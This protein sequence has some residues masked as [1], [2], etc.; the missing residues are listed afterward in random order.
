[1][2]YQ[3]VPYTIFLIASAL[4]TS[5]LVVYGIRHR[6]A[7]GTN[8]LALCMLIGTLWSVANALE[9]SALT[10]EQKLFWANLQYI[11]YSLGPAAWFFTTCQFTG[12]VHWIQWK[13]VLPL[14]IVPA[15]TIFLVWFDPVWGLVRT[16]FSLTTAG[17]IY[18]LQKQY[19]PWFYVHFA[20]AYALNFASIFLAGRAAL[21]RNSIY[22]GQALFLLGGVSL[23]VTSNLLYLA[24]V[25]L[26]TKHDLTPLVFSVAAGLMFWGIYRVDLF[27]LVPIARER[28]LEAMETGVI[29]VN[30]GGRVV[31]LNPASRRMFSI[32]EGVGALLRDIAPELASLN[33]EEGV[34]QHLEIHRRVQGEERY[35]KVSASA[36]TDQRGHV[37]GTVMA[38]TDITTLKQVQARL[39]LEQ[40][41]AAIAQERA[42]ITQD[43]HDNLGQTLAYSSLQVRAVRR[44]LERGN[45]EKGRQ[46][47][48][49]LGEV[50][51]DVQREMRDYVRGMRTKEYENTSLDALLEKQMNRLKEH[52]GLGSQAVVLELTEHDFGLHEK[53]Q[54]CQIVKEAINNVLKHSSA[55]RVTVRLR[56]HVENWV[57]S[58]I[59]NGVG[60]DPSQVLETKQSGF[61]LS[62]LAER[63]RVL[64]GTMEIR[65]DPGGTEIKVEFPRN[66]GGFNHAHH[67]C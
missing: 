43:L 64:G 6:H 46:Y 38:I 2:H 18:V 57:L 66:D 20:Q 44:E 34:D 53:G 40:Q 30:E 3:F 54:I 60:F 14:L 22:Q 42:R 32:Q 58:I 52:G 41:E 21:N 29:V 62:I 49:R 5:A 25:R 51:H 4:M 9:I 35:F 39:I 26:A 15:L 8:I 56:P 11:A 67:D 36:I 28:V 48:L 10:L 1:M 31:D 63:A 50:L 7:L 23:V 47:L 16:D 24:G 17:R 33:P 37:R 59:D 45:T 27:S 19:G 65:S 12:R 61:G 13:R 55:T